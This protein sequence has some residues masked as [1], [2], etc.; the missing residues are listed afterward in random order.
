MTR[1]TDPQLAPLAAAV[2]PAVVEEVADRPDRVRIRLAGPGRG[3]PL[4]AR[5]ALAMPYRPS[6]G[7]RVL[8]AADDSHAYVVGVLH[9][10]QPLSLAAEDGASVEQVDGALELR[11]PHGR[12]LVRYTSGET[13]LSTPHGDLTLAAPAGRVVLRSGSDVEIQAAR[14]VTHRAGRRLGLQAGLVETPQ[15]A[16]E[17]KQTRLQSDHVEVRSKRAQLTTAQATVVADRVRTTAQSL[18]Q[19]LERYE[20]TAQR[21]IERARDAYRDVEDLFQSRVGRARTMVKEVLLL[22]SRRTV[23]VS[24]DETS[25]DGKRIL[26]G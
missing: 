1:R 2:H 14:D 23:M 25:I 8:V 19:E 17:A 21:I 10:A 7:D 4:S 15:L 16:V 6:A 5:L 26:L 11:D 24:K 22:S 3:E 12:L 20:L 18:V 9:A 13:E